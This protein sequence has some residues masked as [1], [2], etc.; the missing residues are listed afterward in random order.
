MSISVIWDNMRMDEKRYIILKIV[1]YKY[2]IQN[3]DYIN[4]QIQGEYNS[5]SSYLKNEIRN[6]LK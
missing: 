5:L 2:L 6:I 4:K 3:E 1:S